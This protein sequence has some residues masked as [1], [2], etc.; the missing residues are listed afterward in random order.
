M[1][2]HPH[3]RFS[4]YQRQ[5][6]TVVHGDDYVSV[7]DECDLQCMGQCITTKYEIKPKWLGPKQQH[8]QEVRVFNRVVIWEP[9]GIGYG[10]HPR[11]VVIMVEQLGLPGCTAVGTPGTSI[12]SRTTGDCNTLLE[13]HEETQ[14]RVLVARANRLA[15]ERANI[16]FAVEELVKSM[17]RPTRGDWIRLKRLTSYLSGKPVGKEHKTIIAYTDV[18]WAGDKDTRRSTSGGCPVTGTHLIKA[19]AKT[20]TLAALSLG[21]LELCAIL[22]TSSEL[23][24]FMAMPEDWGYIYIYICMYIYIYIYAGELAPW[25]IVSLLLRLPFVRVGGVP[26]VCL[27][28]S[29]C[30]FVFPW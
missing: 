9:D 14:Y 24:G 3:V 26:P 25:Q 2:T 29:V 18:D 4:H 10:T 16:F 23:Q 13:S 8:D 22:R 15:P 6:R 7:G 30:L 28:V 20:Q 17:P 12:E 19:W 21:E 27:L 5:I 1:T 11:H